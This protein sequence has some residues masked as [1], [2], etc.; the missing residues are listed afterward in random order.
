MKI[1]ILVIGILCGTQSNQILFDKPF[2]NSDPE[3]FVGCHAYPTGI[4]NGTTNCSL[5]C[6]GFTGSC[7]QTESKWLCKISI[8][9]KQYDSYGTG[10]GPC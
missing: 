8:N 10:R 1:L 2:S 3:I 5:V 9:G 4:E 7:S 6:N